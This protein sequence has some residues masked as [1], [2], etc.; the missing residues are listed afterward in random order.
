MFVNN[1]FN[2][3]ISMDRP[4]NFKNNRILTYDECFWFHQVAN[5]KESRLCAPPVSHPS[6]CTDCISCGCE[7]V[8]LWGSCALSHCLLSLAF[9]TRWNHASIIRKYS[10]VFNILK[11]YYINRCL[12]LVVF[13]NCNIPEI[14]LNK[15]N[16][17]KYV[18][19]GNKF[20]LICRQHTTELLQGWVSFLLQG[21]SNK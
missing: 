10:V 6:L 3:S 5:A 13:L 20:I 21:Q 7:H 8:S 18:R 12:P 16:F 15:L 4:E 14:L 19:R 2:C 17:I 11:N 9:T 1:S